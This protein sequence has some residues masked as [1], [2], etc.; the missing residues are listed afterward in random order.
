ML[1]SHWPLLIFLAL[2]L[3]F[4]TLLGLFYASRFNPNT[5]LK[6]HSLSKHLDKALYFSQGIFL[7]GGFLHLLPDAIHQFEHLGVTE[8][9]WGF[10]LASGFFLLLWMLDDQISDHSLALL[11]L[12]LLSIHSILEGLAV[13]LSASVIMSILLFLAILAHK[14]STAFALSIQLNFSRFKPTSRSILFFIFALMSPLGI[15]LGQWIHAFLSLNPT[16]QIASFQVITLEPVFNALAAGTFIYLA[17]TLSPVRYLPQTESHT[18]K[19]KYLQNQNTTIKTCFI[20]IGF[21]LMGV[22]ALWV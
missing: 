1:T 19:N 12:I 10:L 5:A 22:L 4:I 3:F 18:V 16:Q 11:S 2:V 13:G 8:Y 21:I 15:L 17:L 14:F 20:L 9:P 7:G 6:N